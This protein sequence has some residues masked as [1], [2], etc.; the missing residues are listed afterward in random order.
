MSQLLASG[1]QSPGV[2]ASATVLP[3]NIRNWF[4]LGLTDL[5]SLLSEG[6]SRVFFSTTVWKHQFFNAQTFYGPSLTPLHELWLYASLLAT[7]CLCFL[8]C[9]LSCQS[10]F[11]KEQ[12]SF[13]FMATV[14]IH[15]DF[16]AQEKKICHCCYVFPFHFPWSDG[17]GCH[18]LSFSNA[19]F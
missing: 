13:N 8:I 14:T 15:S 9:C 2:S 3:M 17:T 12:V 16:G 18:D 4:P 1:G 5:I 6:L 7:W 10:F 11:C 19:E